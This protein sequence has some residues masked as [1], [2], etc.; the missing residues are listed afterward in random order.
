MHTSRLAANVQCRDACIYF[1]LNIQLFKKLFEFSLQYPDTITMVLLSDFHGE[2]Y[3]FT[4]ISNSNY[5]NITYYAFSHNYMK[6]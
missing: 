3:S 6:N 1:Y 4:V 5:I 2:G